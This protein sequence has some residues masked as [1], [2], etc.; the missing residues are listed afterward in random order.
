MSTADVVIVGGGPAGLATA[1][2]LAQ[3]GLRATVVDKGAP[4]HD[5]PCGEGL[6]PDGVLRLEELGVVLPAA[7]RQAFRGI[8]YLDG[9]LRAEAR[10]PEGHGLGI[11]RPVLHQAL[12]R[13]AEDLG[14]DLRWGVAVEGLTDMGVRTREGE[15]EA[16]WAVGA[17]GLRSRVRRWTDLAAGSSGG[18]RFGVRRHYRMAPWSELVEVYWV[19]GC[20]AYVTPVASGLV[21]VAVLWGGFKSGFDA[22]LARFPELVRRLEGGAVEGDDRGTGPLDQRVR[23]VARG[24]VA[25]IGDAAGYRDAIT[26]EGISLA[27]HQARILATAIASGDLGAYS[28]AVARLTRLPN[29]LIRLLLIAER[30]PWLRRRLIATLAREPALFGCL[31]AIHARQRPVRELG[32]GGLMRL[33]RGLLT[34]PPVPGMN[35]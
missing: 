19:D 26:G 1:I 2:E 22:L 4:G 34:V 10:F 16:D 9:A 28:S 27:L 23:A 11:H 12:V 15:I 21:G 7:E 25:L 31:L 33:A 18:R 32:P 29:A 6:M 35:S 8:R 24:R 3:R 5:K 17:D 13:R 14:I 30:R 20:E